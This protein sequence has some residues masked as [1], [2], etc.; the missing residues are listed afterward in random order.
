MKKGFVLDDKRLED[1]SKFGHDYFDESLDLH[2]FTIIGVTDFLLRF[3][4]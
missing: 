4:K 1:P 2:G 3:I